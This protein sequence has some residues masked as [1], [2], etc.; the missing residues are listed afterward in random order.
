LMYLLE[1]VP[2]SLMILLH[3]CN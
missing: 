1:K 3:Q 2:L